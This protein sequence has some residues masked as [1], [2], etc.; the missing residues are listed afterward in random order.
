MELEATIVGKYSAVDAGARVQVAGR[1]VRQENG[2]LVDQGAGN[3]DPL[4]LAARELVREVVHAVA[5]SYRIQ[6][7]SCA[8]MPRRAVQTRARRAAA[9]RRCRGRWSAPAG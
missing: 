4:L 1:L 6:H 9:V 3:R 7:V 5:E 2:R 8:G